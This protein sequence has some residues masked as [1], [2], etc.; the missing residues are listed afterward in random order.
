MRATQ[1][2]D[3][4]AMML[5]AM[6]SQLGATFKCPPA[7]ALA[8]SRPRGARPVA[9]GEPAAKVLRIERVPKPGRRVGNPPVPI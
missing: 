1:V 2:I 9:V 7:V 6:A 8:K 5:K 4:H 3:A